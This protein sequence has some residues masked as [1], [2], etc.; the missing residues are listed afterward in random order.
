LDLIVQD[1][2]VILISGQFHIHCVINTCGGFDYVKSCKWGLTVELQ[3]FG[4]G[5]IRKWWADC[6]LN[7]NAIG[8]SL[9]LVDKDLIHGFIKLDCELF[10]PPQILV[11]ENK[12]DTS[13]VITLQF[14]IGIF[15]DWVDIA[16]Q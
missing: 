14:I 16:V 7:N 13:I 9:V 3:L 8:W 11:T 15:Y 2:G 5:D 6:G 10:L 12:H 4:L 1:N